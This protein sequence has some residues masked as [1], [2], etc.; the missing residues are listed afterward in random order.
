MQ[1]SCRIYTDIFREA[2]YNNLYAMASRKLAK[3]A[4]LVL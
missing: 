1:V 2:S 3:Y 4:F